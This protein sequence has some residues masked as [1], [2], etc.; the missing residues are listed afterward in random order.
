V[1]VER[2]FAVLGLA[3]QYA[4]GEPAMTGRENLRMVAR[5]FGRSRRQAAASADVVLARLGLTDVASSLVK[6]Y[7]GGSVFTRPENT[8]ARSKV[9]I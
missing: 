3:G 5:L 2:F 8:S 9:P 4:A 6:T 1:L 7:S